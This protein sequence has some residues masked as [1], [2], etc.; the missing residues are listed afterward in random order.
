[1]C[2]LSIAV[3][4]C[5]QRRIVRAG[6]GASPSAARAVLS[7]AQLAMYSTDRHTMNALSVSMDGMR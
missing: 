6:S 4:W 5:A 3:I 1:M 7:V 2:S